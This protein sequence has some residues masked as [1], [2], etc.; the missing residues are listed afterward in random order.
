M[1]KLMADI[2]KEMLKL[3]KVGIDDNFFDIGGNSLNILQVNKKLSTVLAGTLP[4]M[5][6][7]RY[8]TIRSLT[9]FFGEQ[10][11]KAGL[12]R[13]KRAEALTR[14]KSDRMKRYRKKEQKN[15]KIAKEVKR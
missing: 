3:E 12:D 1:E 2:W 14:G 15:R 4:V 9:E 5:I 11:A 13:K 6:M 8:P 7:F 10:E